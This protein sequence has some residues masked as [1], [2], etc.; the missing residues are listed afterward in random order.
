LTHAVE[1]AVFAMNMKM[2]EHRKPLR[3]RLRDYYNIVIY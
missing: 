3:N 2:C 1:Q